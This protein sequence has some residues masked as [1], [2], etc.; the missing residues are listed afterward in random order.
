MISK[1]L[2]K[3]EWRHLKYLLMKKGYTSDQADKE[4]GLEVETIKKNRQ[5]PK[6]EEISFL[7]TFNRL[8]QGSGGIR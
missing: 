1:P 8:K 3:E 5:K 2:S 4:L 6:K 7:D